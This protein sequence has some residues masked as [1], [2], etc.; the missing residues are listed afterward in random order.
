GG[1]EGGKKLAANRGYRGGDAV[2]EFKT[3]TEGEYTVRVAQFAYTSGGP[4]HFYR[5]TATAPPW[6]PAS[7]PPLAGPKAAPVSNWAVPPTAAM[8]D[9][10]D[11]PA[12]G[13]NPL[14]APGGPLVTD[15]EKNGTA[16]DAQEVKVPC[17]I[18]GRVAK[19][20]ER[21]WYKFDAKKGDVWTLEVFAERIGSPVDAFFVLTD[22][23]GKVIVEADDGPDTLS[24]NQFYT[25]GE[26]PGRYRFSVPADGTYKVMVSTREAGVQFGARDQYALRI[27]K[28]SPDFRV[29]AMPLSTHTPEGCTLA[30]GGAAVFAVFAF[31]FD[32]FD[33]AIELTADKLPKGVRCPKQFIGPGQTRGTLVL[34]CDKDANDFEGFVS[35]SASAAGLK[36][37]VRPFTVT[38][39]TPGVQAN[40]TPNTPMIA[41]MDRGDGLALAVR[42]EAP[43]SLAPTETAFT[44]KAGGKF[45]VTLKVARKETFKDGIA[46]ISAVPT[47]GPKPQGNQPY[48]P[49]G[50]AQPNS[51]EIKLSVDVPANLPPGTH[52]LVL[53]GQS[54]APAPKGG[55]NAPVRFPASYAVAP[56]TVT[57]EGAPKK[58]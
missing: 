11:P 39:T 8:A 6:A 23:K 55:N 10:H 46:I 12:P 21:H 37:A 31:R 4:D 25:K 57:V 17:D 16:A 56:I 32:G 27:A 20:N 9:L 29:G 58:K 43:F 38:W 13:S 14:L 53:R 30:K 28:E 2:L 3:Q 34:T 51:T 36:H 7:F 41:R 52:T 47:F 40:Q 48:P 22:D 42:G 18:A 49:V 5:L 33:G 1:E 26:D 15:N 50:T 44:A 24:P 45:D 35:I 19:K 54:A